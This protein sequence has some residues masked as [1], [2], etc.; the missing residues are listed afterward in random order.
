MK[1]FLLSV[2]ISILC[3]ISFFELPNFSVVEEEKNDS[4][5]VVQLFTSQGC[6]SC[7]SAD[8]LLDKLKSEYK[9]SNVMTLSYHVD[10]WDRLG[11]KDPFSKKEFTLLQNAYGFVFNSNRIYTPQAIINGKIQFVGSNEAKMKENLSKI[12]KEPSKN[13]IKLSNIKTS[14]KKISFNYEVM[15]N[16]SE[17]ELKVALVLESRETP[18]K[19]GENG[20]KELRNSNV[21]LDELNISLSEKK[22]EGFIV[23]PDLVLEGESLQLICYVQKNN[24]EITGAVKSNVFKIH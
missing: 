11:W 7:P 16:V 2:S 9:D 12:L 22:G 14:S 13:S 4:F 19:R 8:R 23:I 17:N 15:G 5:A 3:S 10:Y 1:T 18:I 20:G 24:Y 6:S 21:V